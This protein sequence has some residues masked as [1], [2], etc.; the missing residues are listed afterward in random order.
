[1]LSPAEGAQFVAPTNLTLTASAS[2]PDGRIGRV[3]FFQGNAKLGESVSDPYTVTWL[4][5]PAGNYTL[6]A[7]AT[8]NLGGT[9]LSA[10]V[11]ITI[12]AP[13]MSASLSGD[14]MTLAWLNS[15]VNYVLEY[16]SSFTPPVTWHPAPDTPM[17]IGTQVKV[18][19]TIGPGSKFYR[20]RPPL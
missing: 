13:R 9:N 19:I 11:H 16:T 4:D 7:L 5:A 6:F 14:Q 20:L 12:W 10:P 3:E 17:V 15:S 2:D 1:L 8:D 18:T